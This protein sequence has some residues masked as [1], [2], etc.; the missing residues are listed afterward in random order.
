MSDFQDFKKFLEEN[1]KVRDRKGFKT[2]TLDDKH[3]LD[4]Y[5]QSQGATR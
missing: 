5:N 4:L 2:E 3:L 1:M